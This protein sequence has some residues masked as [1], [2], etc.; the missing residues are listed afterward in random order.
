MTSPEELAAVLAARGD[1][2][3]AS[4]IAQAFRRVPRERFTPQAYWVD[5]PGGGYEPRFKGVDP[6]VWAEPIYRNELIVT[7]VDGG[8]EPVP[9]AVGTVSTCSLSAPGIVALMLRLARIE[10]GSRVLEIGTGQGFNT[11]LC[12]ELC[13]RVVVSVEI[14]AG[15]ALGAREN[16]GGY[17]TAVLVGDGKQGCARLGPYDVILSTVALPQVP[18]AWLD[19]LA[20]GGR[21]V[22][23]L[24]RPL[25]R[26]GVARLF[27]DGAGGVA[28]AFLHDGN[29][30]MDRAVPAPGVRPPFQDQ[31]VT[32][33]T[34]LDPRAVLENPD[35]LFALAHALPDVRG[36]KGLY[37]GQPDKAGCFTLW[38]WDGSGSWAAADY[39]P[40]AVMFEVEQYG[41]RALWDELD[42]AY[43][44]WVKLGRPRVEDWCYVVTRQVQGFTL[45]EQRAAR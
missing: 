22:M 25:Y 16:L 35:A 42:T 10:P 11:A 32:R 15:L 1:L 20:P 9:G 14:D 41:P 43:A 8:R 5:A 29:F 17:D 27:D 4:S 36:W 3:P 31:G 23:P 26:W 30:M 24:H 45:T 18:T 28:G 37:D 34:K 38:L 7:Q 6:K 13:G 12:A 21:I 44:S 2:D 39:R 19:Q 33:M 40:G